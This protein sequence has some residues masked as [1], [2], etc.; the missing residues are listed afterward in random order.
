MVNKSCSM[1]DTL[2]DEF[3]SSESLESVVTKKKGK[4]ASGLKVKP[5]LSK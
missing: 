3:G 1:N 5:S 2:Q 4:K